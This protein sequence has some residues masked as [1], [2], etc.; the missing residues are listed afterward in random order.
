MTRTEFFEL[1]DFVETDLGV[2]TAK[3]SAGL[4]FVVRMKKDNKRK[5][6]SHIAVISIFV[7]FRGTLTFGIFT[8]FFFEEY[9]TIIPAFSIKSQ[10]KIPLII[11]T[12]MHSFGSK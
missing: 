2:V 1:T 11:Y 3:A 4:N 12:K 9:K 6:T 10:I 8:Y 7:L 5:A